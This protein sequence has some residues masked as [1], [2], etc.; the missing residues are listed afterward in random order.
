[1][2]VFFLILISIVSG[3]IG[4][5]I[6]T[7]LSKKTIKKKKPLPIKDEE[8]NFELVMEEWKITIQTQMHFNDLIIKFRSIVIS[9]YVTGMG[10]IYGFSDILKANEYLQ[11]AVSLAMVF[12]VS[13]F[14]LDYFY[15]QQLLLGAVSHSH[16]FDDNKLFQ[17]K[18]L[19]GLTREISN[20]VAKWRTKIFIWLFY[21]LPMLV[22]LYFMFLNFL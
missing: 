11:V 22:V 15:Y 20:G 3:M 19:F 12:W 1:M 14:L 9:V 4:A 13:C 2:I 17:E 7:F 10:L 18:G 8:I 21:L 16:K 5:L 6:Q